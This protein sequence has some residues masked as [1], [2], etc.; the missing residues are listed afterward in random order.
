MDCKPRKIQLK[1]QDLNCLEAA[2]RG[3]AEGLDQHQWV[4]RC[5]SILSSCCPASQGAAKAGKQITWPLWIKFSP[6]KSS[7]G[8]EI[9]S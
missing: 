7:F 9:E 2:F 3:P 4:D 5:G 6:S 1:N 8:T